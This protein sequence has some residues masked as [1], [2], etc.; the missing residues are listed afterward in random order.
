MCFEYRTPGGSEGQCIHEIHD[1]M[2]KGKDQYK[3]QSVVCALDS[4]YGLQPV[5]C[6]RDSEKQ[7]LPADDNE[8]NCVE[9]GP[10]G[11]WGWIVVISCCVLQ[12]S[13]L[14]QLMNYISHLC[15]IRPSSHCN[16]SLFLN[17]G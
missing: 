12:V 1:V 2:D 14:C 6:S 3:M 5:V 7:I 17:S 16:L 11:G 4:E 9:D 15:H 13:L 8:N 10:D